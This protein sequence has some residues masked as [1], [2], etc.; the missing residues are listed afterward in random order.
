MV[1][2]FDQMNKENITRL[3]TPDNVS[4]IARSRTSSGIE[5]LYI[6]G[7]LTTVSKQLCSGGSK[8]VYDII[9]DGKHYALALPGTVD[10][11]QIVIAKWNKVLQEPDNTNRLRDLGLYVN[12]ICMVVQATV[13]GHEFPALVMRRYSDHD[14][15]IYDSKNPQGRYHE[16]IK[17]DQQITDEKALSL[18][19]PIGIEIATLVQNGAQLGRDCFNLCAI[20][21]VPHLYLNDLGA[22]TFE[23]IPQGEL[24]RYVDAYVSSALGAFVNT[25]TERVHRGNSYVNSMGDLGNSLQSKLVARVMV[26]LKESSP[27]SRS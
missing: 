22:A 14:F 10:P 8:E 2:E 19:S 21:G 4:G 9:V 27:S 25:V 13:N 6:H 16:L 3:L 11:V 18:F 26:T 23:K 1:D 17:L 20:K 7:R 12:D 5:S 15:P 24:E